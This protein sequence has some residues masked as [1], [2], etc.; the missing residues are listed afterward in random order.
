MT[1]SNLREVYAYQ[2]LDAFYPSLIEFE[3]YPII[4]DQFALFHE[5]LTTKF[6]ILTIFVEP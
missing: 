2:L 3:I 4:A 1:N 5:N 6:K